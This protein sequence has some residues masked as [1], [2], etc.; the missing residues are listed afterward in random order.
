MGGKL[1]KDGLKRSLSPGLKK[2]Y[3]EESS[4]F[5]WII[6]LPRNGWKLF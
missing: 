4:N 6:N 3:E 5:S 2:I 1:L